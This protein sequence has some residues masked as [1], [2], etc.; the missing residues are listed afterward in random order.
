MIRR[1]G[2]FVLVLSLAAAAA[3]CGGD[4]PNGPSG[5]APR[6]VSINPASGPA[7]GG[8]TVTISGS[9]FSS[10][11]IVTI[12]GTPATNVALLNGSTITAVTGPRSAGAA[13]VVVSV[14][15]RTATL[16]AG[17]T[18]VAG[19]TPVIVSIVA[20]GSRANQPE[21]FADLGEEITVTAT[22]QDGDTP[23]GSLTYGWAAPSG[24]FTGSGASVKWRAPQSGFTTPGTVTLSLSVSDG[25]STATGGVV[26]RIHD[27]AKEVG[28]MARLFLEDFSRQTLPPEDVVRNFRDGC[29][30]GGT[31]KQNELLDVRNNQRTHRITQWNLGSPTVSVS[32]AGVC[33]YRA[34]LGDACAAVTV[35]WTSTCVT[36]TRLD[37]TKVCTLGQVERVTGIDHVT[38]T[39]V[40]DRWWLCD[41]DLEGIATDLVTGK[42]RPAWTFKK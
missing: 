18:Y 4:T 27:S 40:T 7:S 35:N 22:V 33:P 11:A 29:G 37:G 36:E 41:S 13:D 1:L 14:G 39:Y 8:T 5:T 3:A 10:G 9:N 24:T 15:G 16:P 38:A 2:F 17:F 23:S 25:G 28:D 6:V 20:R 34:R 31:G 26:V 21:R 12:G 42:V 19:Q 32:F 30:L